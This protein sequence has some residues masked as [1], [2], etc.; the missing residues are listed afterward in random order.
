[1]ISSISAVEK[2]MLSQ[3]PRRDAKAI[4][5]TSNAL[6]DKRRKEERSSTP[7]LEDDPILQE[8]IKAMMKDTKYHEEEKVEILHAHPCLAN[9]IIDNDPNVSVADQVEQITSGLRESCQ[10]GHCPPHSRTAKT[11]S[12]LMKGRSSSANVSR[13]KWKRSSSPRPRPKKGIGAG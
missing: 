11:E 6:H 10:G 3:R 2:R 5:A 9:L 7:I 13:R 4:Y 12:V 8:D 1:M